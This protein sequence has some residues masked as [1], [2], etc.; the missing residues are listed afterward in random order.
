MG[1]ARMPAPIARIAGFR[2]DGIPCETTHGA[3]R[4]K[5]AE[6][7]RGPIHCQAGPSV[8]GPRMPE[9]LTERDQIT[10]AR[11]AAQVHRMA[12]QAERANRERDALRRADDATLRATL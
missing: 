10:L 1:R 2:Y 8:K 6:G 12:E 7:R 9:P 3:C 4:W 5:R 11:T